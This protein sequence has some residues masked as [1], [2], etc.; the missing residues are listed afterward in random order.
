MP[1]STKVQKRFLAAVLA[2]G[3]VSGTAHASIVYDINLTVGSGSIT[4]TLETDSSLGVLSTGDIL[5]WDFTLNDGL[6]LGGLESGTQDLFGT[7]NLL[8]ASPTELFFDFDLG[9]G[10]IFDV[11]TFGSLRSFQAIDT[12]TGGGVDIQHRLPDLHGTGFVVDGGQV[13]F[14]TST[15]A[16]S[17]P[18]SIGLLVAGLLGLVLGMRKKAA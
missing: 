1:F 17:E 10:G 16:L 9:L 7:A 2:V 14:G 11:R 5:A 3:L 8:T 15:T 12:V 13:R 4:G 18:S 6:H